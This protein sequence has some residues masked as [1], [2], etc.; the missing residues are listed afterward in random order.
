MWAQR[1]T[2]VAGE[3]GGRVESEA[4]W[5]FVDPASGRPRPLDREQLEVW[6]TSAGGHRVRARLQHPAPPA[7]AAS[8]PW[9]FR[10]ADLD[11]ADH[12]NNAA[13]WTVVEQDLAGEV[14]V[15][16]S[17]EVEYRGAAGA[18]D[19]LVRRDGQRWWICAPDG[20]VHASA[21]LTMNA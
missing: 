20:Q 10:L 2:T 14:A 15:P 11:V 16:V 17:A 5:V 9:S 1:R 12:V 3:H 21:V 8:A 6:G 7:D 19:A 13:Y 4:L 18:G